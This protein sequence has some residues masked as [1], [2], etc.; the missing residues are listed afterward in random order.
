MSGSWLAEC[1]LAA[2]QSERPR[3]LVWPFGCPS[4]QAMIEE[5][6]RSGYR[7]LEAADNLQQDDGTWF[8]LMRDVVQLPV[9]ML[10]AVQAA[11]RKGFWRQA[12]D[13][14]KCVRENAAREA[15]RQ[16]LSAEP[17]AAKPGNRTQAREATGE[18]DQDRHT[19][20]N[21]AGGKLLR[22][23]RFSGHH[24]WFVSGSVIFVTLHGDRMRKAGCTRCR[25]EPVK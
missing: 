15:A 17:T 5:H 8:S 25:L 22:E 16:G 9:W 6:L 11:V 4:R 20:R 7:A 12:N 3:R 13:P 21:L 2:A 10:P 14:I 19:A 1:R 23:S 24:L 18:R